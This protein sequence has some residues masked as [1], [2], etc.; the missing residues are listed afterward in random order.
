[1]E[2]KLLQKAFCHKYNRNAFAEQR[3]TDR[4]TVALA[5]VAVI[6]SSNATDVLK[7]S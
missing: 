3:Q 5:A 4:Q 6:S 7:F 2:S 1:M